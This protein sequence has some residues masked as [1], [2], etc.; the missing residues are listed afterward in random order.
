MSVKLDRAAASILDLTY[1]DM[2]KLAHFLS[3][4][5][6]IDDN[7]EY[8][9]EWVVDPGEMAAN[10]QQMAEEIQIGDIV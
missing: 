3:N 6:G 8:D 4:C 9:Y 1:A 7:G 10:L 2:M 5:T